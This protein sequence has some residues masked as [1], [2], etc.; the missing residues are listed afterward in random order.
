[1]ATVDD[2]KTRFDEKTAVTESRK[3]SNDKHELIKWDKTIYSYVA[4]R[5]PEMKFKLDW[6]EK[7]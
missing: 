1:M 2:G 3:L 5:V 6:A 7:F 4:G